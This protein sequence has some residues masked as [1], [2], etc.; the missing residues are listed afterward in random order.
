MES[1]FEL[2][3]T[4]RSVRKFQD[5]KIEKEKIDVLLKSALMSPASK[6][7][8]PW[9]FI[10]V[11]DKNKIESLSKSKPH[12]AGF[13]KTAPLAIVVCADPKKSDVWV[14]DTAIASAVLH[15]SAH[16]LGLGSCWV[17]IRKRPHDE[18][19]SAEDYIK[20]LLQ[21]DDN[22]VVES[23][24]AIGYADEEKAPFDEEKMLTDRLYNNTFLDKW[25]L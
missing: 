4:R 16:D 12:G 3:R 20:D 23:V 11:D 6:R 1:L 24:I 8:N 17:Q 9:S 21:I 5:K 13:M 2:I 18:D 15:L 10:V 19:I 22:M 25:K 14:E 7:S